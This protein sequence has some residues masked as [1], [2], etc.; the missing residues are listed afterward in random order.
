MQ[1]TARVYTDYK[2]SPHL[3]IWNDREQLLQANIDPD[4]ALWVDNKLQQADAAGQ[5]IYS[6]DDS[7]NYGGVV[8]NSTPW[9]MAMLVAHGLS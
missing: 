7:L 4:V 8:H 2:S 5:G 1:I 9:K 3:A 6:K